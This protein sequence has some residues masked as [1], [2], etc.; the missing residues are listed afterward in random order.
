MLR[1]FEKK[2]IKTVYTN[3]TDTMDNK[4]VTHFMQL[5][6]EWSFYGSL[7]IFRQELVILGFPNVVTCCREVSSE[8]IYAFYHWRPAQVQA[9][10]SIRTD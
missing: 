5:N 6:A 8:D 10:L 9:R 3:I 4:I 2:R 7:V 1:G